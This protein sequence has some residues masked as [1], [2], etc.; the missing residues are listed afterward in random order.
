MRI[1]WQTISVAFLVAG[2]GAVVAFWP[3]LRSPDSREFIL[4]AL[5]TINLFG[6]AVGFFRESTR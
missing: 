1:I 2:V 4:H 3:I 5:V 6:A